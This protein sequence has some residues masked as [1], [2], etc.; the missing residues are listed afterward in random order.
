MLI[1]PPPIQQA[2]AKSQEAPII[3]QKPLEAIDII[4]NNGHEV[5]KESNLIPSTNESPKEMIIRNKKAY[6]R[7]IKLIKTGKF[8]SAILSSKVIG[9]QRNTIM[10][11]MKTKAVL[12]CMNEEVSNYIGKIQGNKDWKAQAYLLDRVL[13]DKDKENNVSTDMKQLIVINT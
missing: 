7:F 13:D 1:K 10:E 6:K 5:T 9:V 3:N 12:D 2:E 4:K 8:T 11:W